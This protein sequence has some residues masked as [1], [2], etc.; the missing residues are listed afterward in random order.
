MDSQLQFS[1]LSESIIRTL[2]YYDLFDYPLSASEIFYRLPTNHT[3]LHAVET[4]LPLLERQAI[5]FRFGKY[6][7]LQN[8]TALEHRRVNGNQLAEK[9]M[10][11][12]EEK[13][14]LIARFP[15]VLSVMVSGSLSKGYADE[16]SD[17]DFFIITQPE[18]LWIARMLLVLY[19]RIFLM[20]SHK[21]FCVN[22]FIDSSH[23]EIGEKNIFTATEL[24]TLVPLSGVRY[25]RE[26]INHNPWISQYFQFQTGFSARQ[27][28]SGKG[29]KKKT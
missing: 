19:K 22:Y 20:N 27:R 14:K 29:V 23:L 6:Y 17:I 7:S 16:Q 11:I 5:V 25:Y 28:N 10:R 3:S 8:N 2:A 21:Y 4:E 1:L 9:F 13:A 15:F 18:R 26:L 12:A 24:T